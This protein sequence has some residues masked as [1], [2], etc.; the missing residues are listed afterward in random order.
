MNNKTNT[1]SCLFS[2]KF[3]YP[4]NVYKMSGRSVSVYTNTSASH[5]YL[6][7]LVQNGHDFLNYLLNEKM[8]VK[9]LENCEKSLCKS[10]PFCISVYSY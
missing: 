6:C 4:C 9:N 7:T 3:L 2:S 8:N 5:E 1:Y 10:R